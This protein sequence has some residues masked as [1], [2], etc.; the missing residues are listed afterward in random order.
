MDQ[1]EKLRLERVRV[2]KERRRESIGKGAAQL[3]QNFHN[4]GE[5]ST[6]GK[7][8]KTAAATEWSWPKPMSQTVCAE[9]GRSREVAQPRSFGAWRIWRSTLI[10]IC[11]FAKL[12]RI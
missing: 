7:Q 10:M 11:L 4:F 5:A 8:P 3:Q 1:G 6:I 12:M 2:P 9:H